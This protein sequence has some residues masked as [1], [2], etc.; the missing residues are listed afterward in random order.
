MGDIMIYNEYSDNLKWNDKYKSICPK[1]GHESIL[2]KK[3]IY[4]RKRAGLNT[5]YCRTC[6]KQEA[7]YNQQLKLTDD[8]KKIIA[9]K[10]SKSNK[11]YYNSLSEDEKNEF[12]NRLKI[13]RNN[14]SDEKK[15][16]IYKRQSK[17][18][19]LTLSLLSDDEKLRRN[20]I[21]YDSLMNYWNNLTDEEYKQICERMSIQTK[22]YWKHMNE[23]EKNNRRKILSENILSL[24]DDDW[25]IREMNISKGICN[26]CKNNVRRYYEIESIFKKYGYMFIQEYPTMVLIDNKYDTSFIKSKIEILYYDQ[27]KIDYIVK[28]Q[29][30]NID[31][32]LRPMFRKNWDYM[33]YIPFTDIKIFIDIDDPIHNIEKFYF[34][35][36]FINKNGYISNHFEDNITLN[37]IMKYY[38]NRRDG[39]IGVNKFIYKLNNK[40]S[41]GKLES[42]LYKFEN[43]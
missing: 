39:I 26:N 2:S 16:E 23:K 18:L 24:S 28:Y 19:K 41:M 37:D 9:D 22:N 29:D 35:E 13:A 36:I 5:E 15:K 20:K 27:N 4:D 21:L 12:K 32:K 42:Y 6:L 40:Q 25:V 14:I 38:D 17:S 8:E 33:C 7:G 34:D 30:K 1:C 43:D 31:G 3:I 11:E 10:I